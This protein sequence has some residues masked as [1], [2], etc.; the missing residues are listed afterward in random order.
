MLALQARLGQS[1]LID[2]HIRWAIEQQL[3]RRAAQSIDVQLPQKKRLI[4]AIEKGLPRD[5]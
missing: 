4:R 1:A 2:E 3:A 5:A